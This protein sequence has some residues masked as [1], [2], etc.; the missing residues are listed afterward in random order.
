MGGSISFWHPQTCW[1]IWIGSKRNPPNPR[2]SIRLNLP[3]VNIV[4]S[5]YSKWIIQV[6][7]GFNIHIKLKNIKHQTNHPERFRWDKT[8]CLFWC[9]KAEV[10]LKLHEIS[11]RPMWKA[12]SF[13]T[14]E[15][16]EGP[17]CISPNCSFTFNF[18]P[19][20]HYTQKLPSHLAQPDPPD[21]KGK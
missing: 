20:S 18:S 12:W 7:G 17:S 5:L 11:W 1:K 16:L 10:I 21:Q 2:L 15:D 13:T 4:Y 8:W 19:E 9:S 6:K 3:S 14:P